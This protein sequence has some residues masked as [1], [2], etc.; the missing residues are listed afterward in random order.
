MNLRRACTLA[1]RCTVRIGIHLTPAAFSKG[2]M[3][4]EAEGLGITDMQT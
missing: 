2:A 1:A 3:E 4:V